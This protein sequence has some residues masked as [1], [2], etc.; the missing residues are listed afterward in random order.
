MF[1]RFQLQ[2]TIVGLMVLFNMS[3]ISAAEHM[4]GDGWNS[5]RPDSH[6]PV[7]VMGD[8]VHHKG[9]WM[10]SYRYMPMMM[11][12]NRSGTDGVSVSEVHNN[13]MVAP[14]EMSMN[15]HM[16]GLMVAPSDRLTL[17]AMVNYLDTEMKLR[18]RAGMNFTTESSGFGDL[19]ISG[20]LVLTRWSNSQL[21]ANLGMSLPTGATDERGNTPMGNDQKL[22]YPM[23]IGSGTV[24]FMP[25]L[26]YLGQQGNYSWGA[27]GIATFRSGENDEGYTLG[28]RFKMSFWGARVWNDWF[29]SSLRAAFDSWGNIDGADSE[30]NPMMV[31]TARTDLRGG[32]RLDMSLG[33]NMYIRSGNLKGHRIALELSLPV[34]QYL[35]GP[36]LETDWIV[37]LGWQ[38]AF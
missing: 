20:L 4:H 16:V 9:E 18:T 13:F 3:F 19:G 12:G 38:K 25:G 5:S 21:H 10:L 17:M 37:T 11:K 1:K 36:Q 6:A 24:D 22:P 31:P 33:T 15:M 32:K 26:T 28:D 30:L 14:L 8:H 29:S 2:V 7:G 35:D 27:Q 34:Y 23:Q